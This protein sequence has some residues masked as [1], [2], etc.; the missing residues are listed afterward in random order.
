MLVLSRKRDE[1]IVIGGPGKWTHEGPITLTVVEIVGGFKTRIGVDAN[2]E[3]PV[4]RLEVQKAIE[5]SKDD[6]AA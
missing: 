5:R 4:H 6:E 1:Q 2:R 3:L